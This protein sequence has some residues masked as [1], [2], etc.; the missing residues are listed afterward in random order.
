VYNYPNR[1]YRGPPVARNTVVTSGGTVVVTNASAT[2]APPLEA[3][4]INRE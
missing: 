1:W 2:D 4:T 3:L